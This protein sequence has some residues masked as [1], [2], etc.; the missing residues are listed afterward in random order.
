MSIRI[1]PSCG[2]KVSTTRDACSH[3]GHAFD[4]KSI[5]PECDAEIDINAEVCP[6]CGYEFIRDQNSKI[7]TSRR[8]K[9]KQKVASILLWSFLGFTALAYS[10]NAII[11]LSVGGN[12]SYMFEYIRGGYIG[13]FICMG[14]GVV[15][16]ITTLIFLFIDKSLIGIKTK[17]I[18]IALM[19][20]L[21]V[22]TFVPLI[23]YNPLKYERQNDGTYS[24]TQCFK[25]V[26]S[27]DIPSTY[28]G[29]PVTKIG[30]GAFGNCEKLTS[31]TLPDSIVSIG[32]AAFYGCKNLSGISIPD[33]VSV[34][35]EDAFAHC[36]SLNTITIPDGVTVIED[37]AFQ[38][39]ALK[40][41]S[42]PASL[43]IIDNMALYATDLTSIEIPD[44]VTKIGNNA[45]DYC[46][47]LRTIIIPASVTT[48]GAM[49]WGCSD[50]E[51]KYRGTESEWLAITEGIDWDWQAG[52]YTIIYDY[53]E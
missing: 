13:G 51:I 42:L 34:I 48:L 8:N 11:A 36:Y 46:Y 7:S 17:I 1:C 28:W 27:V 4:L 15:G 38:Y 24:V 44:G 10:I 3:C 30:D 16:F 43:R 31:V 45:F 47:D 53:S 25:S 18:S 14:V 6:V 22:V 29:A 35:G 52:A 33:R 40:S 32:N 12:L 20:A 9:L 2:G 39:S 19:V 26:G 49:F 37:R 21:L 50:F 5:C 41:I 23:F